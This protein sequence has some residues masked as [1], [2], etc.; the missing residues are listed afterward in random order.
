V[1]ILGTFPSPRSREMG[2]YYG[3]P[4]NIFWSTLA[5]VL[6]ADEPPRDV[7]MRREFLLEHRVALWDVLHACTI[8]G[9]SD[10]SITDPVANLFA[11]VLAS[12]RIATI[13]TTGKA[14]TGLFNRLCAEEAGMLATYL[15]STSPANRAAQARPAFM[16]QW[17]QVAS[18]LRQGI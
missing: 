9:A 15:P 6:E 5:R 8:E 17:M 18:A 1:L 10:A 16:Q 7:Q 13:F 14:A 12:S 2:F 3:H 4:Q 11:P